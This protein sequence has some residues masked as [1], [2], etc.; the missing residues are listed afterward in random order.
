MIIFAKIKTILCWKHKIVFIF[1]KIIITPLRLLKKRGVCIRKFSQ[2]VKSESFILLF[3]TKSNR[4]PLTLSRLPACGGG[5][6]TSPLGRG[7]A[8]RRV[9]APTSLRIVGFYAYNTQPV[10]RL[11]STTNT[12]GAR[13][14]QCPEGTDLE[15]GA[16]ILRH[17]LLFFS[18][19]FLYLF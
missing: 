9:G 1:A 7:L 16:F 19:L 6:P 11:R 17:P 3:G 2:W 15:W 14:G 18:F 4:K 13:L 10:R 12:E 8:R 5:A